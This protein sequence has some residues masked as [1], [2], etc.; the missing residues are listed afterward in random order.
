ME[1]H[2]H[3]AFR[4]FMFQMQSMMPLISYDYI[5]CF[6]PSGICSPCPTSHSGAPAVSATRLGCPGLDGLV[7]SLI[8]QG[9]AGPTLR[10]YVS[11]KQH[12]LDFCQWFGLATAIIGVNASA[13]RGLSSIIWFI[14]QDN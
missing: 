11:E 12:C 13:I 8:E 2:T 4:V 3:L 9:V 6:A 10:A 7:P 5:F 1:Y 14:I